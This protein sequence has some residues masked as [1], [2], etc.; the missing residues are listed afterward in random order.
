MGWIARGDDWLYCFRDECLLY[1]CTLAGGKN[2][3]IG[4]PMSVTL[5]RGAPKSR[6]NAFLAADG[7]VPRSGVS[8]HWHAAKKGANPFTGSIE[9][10]QAREQGRGLSDGGQVGGQKR[11]NKSATMPD[12]PGAGMDV[13]DRIFA[14]WKRYLPDGIFGGFW[15]LRLAELRQI[16]SGG[17]ETADCP[18]HWA[19]S[20]PKHTLF[21]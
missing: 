14:R 9:P 2:V 10:S 5:R 13:M 6:S 18:D 21:S 15:F 11:D 19:R 12:K 17:R 4:L 7:C 8:T 1:K 3:L 16:T 20:R